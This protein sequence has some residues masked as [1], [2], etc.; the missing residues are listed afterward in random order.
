VGRHNLIELERI[1]AAELIARQKLEKKMS[2]PSPTWTKCSKRPGFGLG[3]L[4]YSINIPYIRELKKS[5]IT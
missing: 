4:L 5:H 2:F 3:F 1:R